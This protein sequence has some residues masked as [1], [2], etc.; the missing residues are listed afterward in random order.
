MENHYTSYYGLI[1]N[2]P[3][4]SEI[5]ECGFVPIRQLR[6]KD[7]LSYYSTLTEHEKQGLIK[8][9]KQCLSVREK[10]VPFSR[11]AIM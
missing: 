6:I 7:R 10:K 5:E 3:V 9:H 1:F 11:I 2:C 8:K 4:G